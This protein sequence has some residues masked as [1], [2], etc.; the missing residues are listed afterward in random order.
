MECYEHM[1]DHIKW[2]RTAQSELGK[3]LRWI[4]WERTW[5]AAGPDAPFYESGTIL[6]ALEGVRR[7]DQQR[8]LDNEY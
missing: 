4:Y 6:R 3:V 2:M 7:E 5:P 1:S 8:E